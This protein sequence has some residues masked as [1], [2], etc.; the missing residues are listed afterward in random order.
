MTLHETPIT[1]LLYSQIGYDRGAPKRAIVRSTEADYLPVEAMFAVHQNDTKVLRDQVVYWGKCWGSHWWVA[2]FSALDDAGEYQLHIEVAGERLVSTDTFTIAL[3][4]LWDET[5]RIMALDQFEARADLALYGKGWKDCGADW[6]EVCSH[7]PALIGLTDLLRFGYEYLGQADTARLVAQII[8]GC[9]YLVTCQER[10]AALGLP[11]GALVHEMPNH[12]VAIPS[13]HG[14]AVVALARAAR[15][16][17]EIDPERSMRYLETASKAFEYLIYRAQPYGSTNFSALNHGA[18][19]DY[20]PTSFMT[21]DLLQMVWAGVELI[22]GG[23]PQYKDDVVRIARQILARQVPQSQPEGE[24]YGHFY[25]F[26][27]KAF[28]EKA[29][30][31]HHVGHDTGMMF[32]HY[33]VALLDLI[34]IMPDH[35]DVPHWQQAIR[36]FAYGYFLPACQ[37]NP[38]YLLPIGYFK[39]QGLLSFCGP[40]HGFNVCYGFAASLAARLE[41]MFEDVAF[42]D[43]A[44]GN[45]QWLAGLNA[46]ITPGSFEGC[47]MWR[48]SVP[49]GQAVPHSL[50]YGIGTRYVETWTKVP[51]SVPNGFATN[52]QFRLEVEPTVAN[53]GPWRFTDEDW[54]PHAAG[55]LSALTYLRMTIRFRDALE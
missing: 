43:V 9:D 5:V 52:L 40:W 31:H 30:A 21:A 23:R 10:G 26:E 32:A 48:G 7:A 46:G 1:G 53:D 28:T 54:I 42:R 19:P 17:Y 49:E 13:D 14:Q 3:H 25:T 4:R 16:L 22:R 15:L 12:P 6:R 18:P 38:F 35:P 47:V 51:G 55:W 29:F 45:L 20:V 2:D 34:E 39:D 11:S 37:Q 8:H 50:I 41:M 36:N 33:P 27:D 44:V 24:F